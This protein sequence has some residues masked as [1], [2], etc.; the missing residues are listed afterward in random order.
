[1]EWGFRLK[2]Q[3][4]GLTFTFVISDGFHTGM[5]LQLQLRFLKSFVEQTF[6]M[7]IQV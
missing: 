2:A 7:L 3:L 6:F 4:N 5:R 1:M